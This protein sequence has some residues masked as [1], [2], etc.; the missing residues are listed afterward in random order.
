MLLLPVALF[1]FFFFFF[2]KWVNAACPVRAHKRISHVKGCEPTPLVLL[3]LSLTLYVSIFSLTFRDQTSERKE[4]GPATLKSCGI[5]Q[6]LFFARTPTPVFNETGTRRKWL[7]L[8]WLCGMLWFSFPPPPFLTYRFTIETSLPLAFWWPSNEI[9]EMSIPITVGCKN[10][11]SFWLHGTV[12]EDCFLFALIARSDRTDT[13]RHLTHVTAN[14]ITVN[15]PRNRTAVINKIRKFA[16][17]PLKVFHWRAIT[18]IYAI[19][20]DID[21]HGKTLCVCSRKELASFQ[22]AVKKTTIFLFCWR[23]KKTL[24][25]IPSE[26]VVSYCISSVGLQSKMWLTKCLVTAGAVKIFRFG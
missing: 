18:L 20:S 3:W 2:F 8:K 26:C 14:S 23:Q 6:Q 16:S 5:R 13:Q 15:L 22:T 1:V 25:K 24:G 10:Q 9:G 21:I 12:T 11:W 19:L 17:R 4:E 7:F